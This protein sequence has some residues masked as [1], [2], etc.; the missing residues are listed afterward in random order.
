MSGIVI[1]RASMPGPDTEK[2]GV[3]RLLPLSLRTHLTIISIVLTT[4]PVIIFGLAQTFMV[5]AREISG[6]ASHYQAVATSIAREIDFFISDATDNLQILSGSIAELPHLGAE[7]LEGRVRRA[8]D[9]RT[10][11]HIAVMTPSGRSVVNL[12]RNEK[13]PTGVDYSDRP[14]LRDVIASRRPQLSAPLLGR[15]SRRPEV[16]LAFPVLD[17][18]G[19]LK[20]ILVGGLDMTDLYSRHLEQL[21]GKETRGR[22]FLLGPSGRPL[23][24]SDRKLEEVF[25]SSA[26]VRIEPKRWDID[27]RLVTWTDEEGHRLVGASASLA[28]GQWSIL[29]GIPEDQIRL[30]M[31]APMRRAA[32]VAFWLLL[33]CAIVSPLVARMLAAPIVALSLIHI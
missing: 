12:T 3:K 14:Y 22:I 23:A 6:A 24:T 28:T 15:V 1:L 17:R 18:H 11:D 7:A 4:G 32:L 8:L 19:A 33:A 13:L 10:I 26:D 30:A 31:A 16:F 29:S 20:A 27:P 5:R 2:S 9:T 25:P 21:G